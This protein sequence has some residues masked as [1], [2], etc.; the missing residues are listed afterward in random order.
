M[1]DRRAVIR[2]L[3]FIV[4]VALTETHLP[5]FNISYT[6]VKPSLWTAAV[7]IRTIST[8]GPCH[9]RVKIPAL[10]WTKRGLTVI[11]LAEPTHVSRFACTETIVLCGVI[12]PQPGPTTPKGLVLEPMGPWVN[13]SLPE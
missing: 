1:A 9:L 11:C 3:L 5:S 6:V 12:H 7:S 8:K 10:K 4:L 13:P 2:L